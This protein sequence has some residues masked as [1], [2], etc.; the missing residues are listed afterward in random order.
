MSVTEPIPFAWQ[1]QDADVLAHRFTLP[2]VLPPYTAL[3]VSPGQK[4]LVFM[5]N[6]TYVLPDAG[7][8]LITASLIHTIAEGTALALENYSGAVLPYNCQITL[9]D[10]RPKI[11]HAEPI[12]LACANGDHLMLNLSLN[13]CVDDVE[14]LD[15]CGATYQPLDQASEMRQNDPVI[16]SALK[17]ALAAATQRLT[18]C[19]ADAPSA[20]EATSLVLSTRVRGDIMAE[21]HRHLQP[22]G[23]KALPV[24]ICP[25]NVICPYCQKPL[26]LTELKRRFCSATD[27]EGNPQKGCNRKLHACPYCQTIVGPE[28]AFCPNRKCQKELLFCHDAG[29]QTYRIVE[30]GRFCPVCKRACYPLQDREFLHRKREF[31]PRRRN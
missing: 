6:A 2:E 16:D 20:Q 8:Q 24:S 4:G 31:L 9:F 12:D 17:N 21:V 23:L 30:R 26:S 22:L 15:K 3:T 27:D 14:K 5:G 29:C 19:A 25:A 13:F 7:L 10:A 18:V 1:M 28:H 11:W